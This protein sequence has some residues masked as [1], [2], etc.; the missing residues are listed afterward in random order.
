MPIDETSPTS[1][2]DSSSSPSERQQR[3]GLIL[4]C[5]VA[6]IAVVNGNMIN[7]ALPFIGHHFE[8]SEGT[9]GWLVT[10]FS[11]TFGVFSA[12]HGRLASRVGLR[13]LY[14]LGVIVLGLTSIL[15]ALT[16][17]IEI[18][19]GL[20]V[21]QG[22]GSAA[23]PTLATVILA[24]LYAQDGRGAA[25][26]WFLGSIG[27]AASIGPFLGGVLVEFGGWRLVFAST[28]VVLLMVPL[29]FSVLPDFLDDQDART[30]DLVGAALMGFGVTA[31]LYAFNLLERLGPGLEV[32]SALAIGL[33]LMALLGWW[34]P[35]QDD[36]FIAPDIFADR[37]YLFGSILAFLANA[38]RFGTIVLVPIFLVEVNQVSPLVVGLVLFPGA[39][40][41]ALISPLSGRIGDSHGAR[42][43]VTWGILLVIAGSLVTA[44]TTGAHPIGA[45]AGMGLFGLGFALIQSP[46]LSATTQILPERHAG[47]GTG[48]FMMIYFLGGGTGVALS[49][50]AVELQARDATSWIGLVDPGAAVYSNAVLV[51]AVLGIS[52]L[53]LTPA[54][55]GLNP[56]PSS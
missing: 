54:L 24:R 19:I 16:P 37:R 8:V 13:R 48:V 6:F 35:R 29:I 36:P 4:L 49:V 26:G 45:A 28:S 33:G 1:G 27:V 9:Y 7:V 20:R 2:P 41:V 34:L 17:T 32:A 22:A 53:F 46:L 55:P 44:A 25:M 38:A 30:F 50:T 15:L 43:P 51:L 21:L 39:L 3:L 47:T 18:A 11:L 56:K 31:L 40:A 14:A 52:S 42:I 23:M 10:G 12:V 5:S